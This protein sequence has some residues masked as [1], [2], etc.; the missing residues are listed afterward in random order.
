MP[1]IDEYTEM[2][3]NLKQTLKGEDRMAKKKNIQEEVVNA[4]KAV[5]EEKEKT[6]IVLPAEELEKMLEKIEYR[7]YKGL[8]KKMNKIVQELKQAQNK[9]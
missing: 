4:E 6:M 7:L 2:L 1:S 8:A 3:E 9:D 5:E